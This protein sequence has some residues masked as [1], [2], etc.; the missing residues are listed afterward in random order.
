MVLITWGSLM[1]AYGVEGLTRSKRAVI[2]SYDIST[3]PDFLHLT[4]AKNSAHDE[5]FTSRRGLERE[6]GKNP[7]PTMIFFPSKTELSIRIC[8][9]KSTKTSGLKRPPIHVSYQSHSLQLPNN[10]PPITKIQPTLHLLPPFLEAT[11]NPSPQ[12]LPFP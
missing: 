8:V 12:P 11:P 5:Q 2:H 10:L 1:N 3:D 9:S 4:T 6:V 7:S